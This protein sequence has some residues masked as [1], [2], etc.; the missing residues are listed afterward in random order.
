MDLDPD[1]GPDPAIFVITVKTPT[2]ILFKKKFFCLLLFEGT[3]T[4]FFQ[5]K[6]FK[7]SH[8]TVGI[9]VF[10]TIFA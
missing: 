1:S 2:K 4:S 10:L 3:F 5:G 8:N 9:K 7:R 6:K